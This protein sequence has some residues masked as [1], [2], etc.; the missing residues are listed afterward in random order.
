VYLGNGAPDEVL[1]R[2]EAISASPY[3][4]WKYTRGRARKYVFLDL[5]R[6]G[7]YVLI[8]TDDRRESSRP[9]WREL[10]GPEAA[11]DVERF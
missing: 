2:P 11:R 3:E 9:N 1:S 10:L 7:N 6:F 5:T 8:W 4:V